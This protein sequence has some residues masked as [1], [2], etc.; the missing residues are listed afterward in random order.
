MTTQSEMTILLK[1][2]DQATAG[3]AKATGGVQKYQAQL[4]KAG[5]VATASGAA[6]VGALG[7]AVKSAAA[8]D[9]SMREVNSLMGLSNAEFEKLKDETL[10]MASA[11]G[12]DA[13]QSA[14][15]LYQAISAGVPRGNAVEFLAVASKAAIAG[16]TTTETAVDGLTTVINAFGK[17]ISE[18]QEVADVMF[19]AVK[20]GKTTFDE[21]SASMFQVAPI[22]AAMDID[23]RD[24]A[25]A[26]A[27]LTKQ[28]VPTKIAMTQLRQAMVAL[29]K[30]TE[31]MSDLIT[32]LG[33]ASGGALIDAHGLQGAL[34]I[35]ATQSGA[36]EEELAKAFGSVEALG[37]VLGLTGKQAEAAAADLQASY[38][39]A[40]AAT[41][42]YEIVNES[43]SRQLAIMVNRLKVLSIEIGTVLLP[44]VVAIAQKVG[45][46]LLKIV[47]WAREHETLTKVIVIAAATVGGLLLVLGPLLIMLPALVSGVTLLAGAFVILK[48]ALLA[49]GT[50]SAGPMG[51]V[52]AAVG[53]LSVALAPKLLQKFQ[54]TS[55]GADDLAKAL[56]GVRDESDK[57]SKALSSIAKKQVERDLRQ[58][59]ERLWKLQ[60]Q[61]D[62]KKI[63]SFGEALKRVFFGRDRE[64]DAIKDKIAALR[65]EQDRFTTTL[66][67]SENAYKFAGTTSRQVLDEITGD[68]VALANETQAA[69]GPSFDEIRAKLLETGQR[70]EETWAE[71]TAAVKKQ[72]DDQTT[73]TQNA[74]A[75]RKASHEEYAA[76]ERLLAQRTVDATNAIRF[77]GFDDWAKAAQDNADWIVRLQQEALRLQQEAFLQSQGFTPANLSAA[78]NFG[79]V[80][81]ESVQRGLNLQFQNR[82]AIAAAASVASQ[83][84]AAKAAGVNVNIPGFAHGG[85]VNGPTLAVLGDNP[86][87]REAVIPLPRSGGMPGGVTIVGPLVTAQTVMGGDLAD[88]VLEGLA[89]LKLR[90][91]DINVGGS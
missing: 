38:D 63:D 72:L 5:L 37:A 24:V 18:A 81:I 79:H 2:R 49:L 8:F 90:G 39:S 66:Q 51:L 89:E 65:E 48:G 69:L 14:K 10:D 13:V 73:M 83:V 60:E 45:D 54:K 57:T 71:A 77:K 55:S 34:N 32:G 70:Y 7:L 6:I 28:G 21:L 9:S 1:L 46:F 64:I 85:I 78:Q 33:F 56:K 53:I 68:T 16:V 74:F 76:S 50:A 43:A 22:A 3:M 4:R 67:E 31:S 61:L 20:G 58:V 12:V 82:E 35:L 47:D 88:I 23:F 30:P 86:S 84:A 17:D 11:L 36:T 52:I 59:Q 29:Q 41:E 26:V 42:A 19:T 15:A 27:S 44:I 40:G 25:A 75:Q 62:E 91:V 87:G 80:D